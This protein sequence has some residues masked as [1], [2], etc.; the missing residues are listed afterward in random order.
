MGRSVG[1]IITTLDT[2]VR[3]NI[4]FLA[5]KE[6]IRI[7]GETDLQTKVMVTMF[8]LFAEMER[9]LISQ[10]TR[11][12]LAVA[13]AKG[14]KLGRPKGSLGRS[15]LD[16]K[17]EEIKKLLAL[18]VSKASIAKITG[19][20]GAGNFLL[21]FLSTFGTF[22]R[23]HFPFCK[24]AGS[25]NC[26]DNMV[27][28]LWFFGSLDGISDKGGFMLADYANNKIIATRTKTPIIMDIKLGSLSPIAT[29][30]KHAAHYN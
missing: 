11:E 14:K 8:G 23:K 3:K 21:Y 7:S 25:E 22:C 20:F 9:E 13:K 1:E 26:S 4:R 17:E 28:M 27:D 5:V 2:L 15:K 29:L 10:R 30:K 24:P 6:G 12:A 18:S 19:V 16:G